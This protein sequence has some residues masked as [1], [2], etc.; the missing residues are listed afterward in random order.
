VLQN[1]GCAKW[2]A[3]NGREPVRKNFLV[4]RNLPGSLLL[5]HSLS[6]KEESIVY[7]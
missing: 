3:K 5:F 7:L 2:L 6:H 1:P 4:T